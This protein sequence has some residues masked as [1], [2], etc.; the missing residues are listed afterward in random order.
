MLIAIE[1]VKERIERIFIIVRR[2]GG[3]LVWRHCAGDD[4]NDDP[5]VEVTF[6]DFQTV[7]GLGG[8]FVE[9]EPLEISGSDEE[10]FNRGSGVVVGELR[11]DTCDFVLGKDVGPVENSSVGREAKAT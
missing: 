10:D 1:G 8:E 6:P 9:V 4:E 2:G 5:I 7:S 11:F 3:H